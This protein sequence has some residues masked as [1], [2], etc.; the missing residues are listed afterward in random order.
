I[1]RE[2][3]SKRMIFFP[4]SFKKAFAFHLLFAL[5][6]VWNGL[7]FGQTLPPAFAEAIGHFGGEIQC[8]SLR[9]SNGFIKQGE[10]FK[11]LDMTSPA[12]TVVGSCPLTTDFVADEIYPTRIFAAFGRNNRECS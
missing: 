7:L 11:V 1:G 3:M 8:L 10:Y 4:R 6:L 9:D 2:A 5:A 12:L